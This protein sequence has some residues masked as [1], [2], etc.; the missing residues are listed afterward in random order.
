MDRKQ[1]C[2]TSMTFQHKLIIA[3]LMK[4]G[5][6]EVMSYIFKICSSS[7]EIIRFLQE[8]KAKQKQQQ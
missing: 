2:L 3:I 5:M 7:I 1:V 8:T 4:I 6:S